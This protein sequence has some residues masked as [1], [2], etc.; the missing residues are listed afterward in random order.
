MSG[1]DWYGIDA[2]FEVA[3]ALGAVTMKMPFQR[4]SILKAIIKYNS[5]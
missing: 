2:E 1:C 4:K 3:K 5:S